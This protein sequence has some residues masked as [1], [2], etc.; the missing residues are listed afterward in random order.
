MD[1]DGVGSESVEAAAERTRDRVHRLPLNVVMD[2][3][4]VAMPG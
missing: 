1:M 3:E 2:S 4:G